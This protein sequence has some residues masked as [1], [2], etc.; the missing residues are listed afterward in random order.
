M[1]LKAIIF[2][3]DGLLVDTETYWQKAEIEAFSEVGVA[4]T[5]EDCKRV[6]GLRCDEAVGVF[7]ERYDLR[8]D[9]SHMVSV[10]E[11]KV[12][13]MAEREPKILPGVIQAI[14]LFR[15]LGLKIAVC[16]SSSSRV[17]HGV[18]KAAGLLETF[19]ELVSAEKESYGK[20]H[21]AVYLTALSCLDIQHFEALVFEDSIFGIVAAKAAKIPVVAVPNVLPRT[22]PRFGI[23][24]T[25]IDSMD[26][27]TEKWLFDFL[28]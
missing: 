12:I 1:K 10:I 20:P 25:V 2:D 22:D 11:T 7:L 26:E 8:L 6:M 19:G 27:V 4:L 17:I 23:A 9:I 5:L 24:D 18:L 21:P 3:M 15:R 13:A 16:S 14:E 28:K